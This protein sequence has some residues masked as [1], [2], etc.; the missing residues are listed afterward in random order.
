MFRAGRSSAGPDAVEV[1]DYLGNTPA[2]AR[3]S[4]IDPRVIALYHDGVTIAPALAHLGEDR[5]FGELATRGHAEQAV[6][7]LLTGERPTG[8]REG[9][10]VTG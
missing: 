9:N 8:G 3:S 5:D 6:L 7:E 10:A 4:Y 2:V 1:A